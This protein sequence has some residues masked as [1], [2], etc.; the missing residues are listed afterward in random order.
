MDA[1]GLLNKIAFN[2]PEIA[3]FNI[4]V[5]RLILGPLFTDRQFLP[6]FAFA[7][8]ILKAEKIISKHFRFVALDGIRLLG[9]P[10]FNSPERSG[11]EFE[12]AI[13]NFFEEPRPL[14]QL[15]HQPYSF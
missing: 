14:T 8:I 10:G 12:R 4:R 5:L 9:D 3:F 7:K 13:I 11:I 2:F 15:L 6:N 1:A